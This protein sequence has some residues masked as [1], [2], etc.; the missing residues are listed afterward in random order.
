MPAPHKNVKVSAASLKEACPRGQA[1]WIVNHRSSLTAALQRMREGDVVATTNWHVQ[2]VLKQHA[3]HT[4]CLDDVLSQ[5]DLI[6]INAFVRSTIRGWYLVEGVD[7]TVAGG[8]SLGGV[9]EFEHQ[10]CMTYPTEAL[11][12]VKGIAPFVRALAQFDIIL[13]SYQPARVLSDIEDSAANDALIIACGHFGVPLQ[14]GLRGRSSYVP[15]RRLRRAVSRCA[16]ATVQMMKGIR[17]LLRTRLFKQAM[18][19]PPPVAF[20]P[21]P[22]LQLL[23]CGQSRYGM[24]LEDISPLGYLPRVWPRLSRSCAVR[25]REICERWSA[26]IREPEYLSRFIYNGIRCERFFIPLFQRTVRVGFARAMIQSRILRT[27]FSAL[28]VRAM[29]TPFDEPTFARLAVLV[30]KGA[31]IPTIVAQHGIMRLDDEPFRH[32]ELCT[33][34]TACVFSATDKKL[35]SL[36]RE[37]RNVHVIG[38]LQ[39]DEYKVPGA[40]PPYAARQATSR[41]SRL[42]VLVL[43]HVTSSGGN[44]MRATD[45][46]RYL[47]SVVDGLNPV[48]D[49]VEVTLKLHPADDP[50]RYEANLPLMRAKFPLCIVTGWTLRECLTNCDVVVMP[51]S[52]ALG[53]AVACGKPA[54]FFRFGLEPAPAAFCG[55]SGLPT[56]TTSSELTALV[57]PAVSD[58]YR[59]WQSYPFTQIAVGIGPIDG[60]STER[61]ADVVLRVCTQQAS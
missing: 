3:K 26:L 5:E 30:A 37:A 41:E 10:H 40:R 53:E 12:A 50:E 7:F 57:R 49:G 34:D 20:V 54:I 52:T 27:V 19:G 60:R 25:Y 44:R 9:Y 38:C 11:T 48:S 32:N 45:P 58:Y 23:V 31:G 36:R 55:T 13:R 56:A 47:A 59:Y 15:W 2:Q 16:A 35:L 43:G 6:S 51:V 24:R 61:L 33:A 28:G 29:L 39:A 8:V 1:L 46:E 17:M 42:R 18:G 4:V 21:Y 14:R 22:C